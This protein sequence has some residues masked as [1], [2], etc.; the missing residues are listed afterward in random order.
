MNKLS[1]QILLKDSHLRAVS[2]V[3]SGKQI[4]EKEEEP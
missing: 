4:F 1:K 3:K 2:G